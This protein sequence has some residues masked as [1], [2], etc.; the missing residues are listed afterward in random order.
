MASREGIPFLV[1]RWEGAAASAAAPEHRIDYDR[2]GK[3][4]CSAMQKFSVR[5][6][7]MLLCGRPPPAGANACNAMAT[8]VAVPTTY[9]FAG[10]EFVSTTSTDGVNTSP[11]LK[12]PNTPWL[13]TGI[14][15]CSSVTN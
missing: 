3:T 6:G 14:S 1:I 2:G 11:A 12:F 5:Y 13:W 9:A 7:C 4:P 8:G 10:S 15:L